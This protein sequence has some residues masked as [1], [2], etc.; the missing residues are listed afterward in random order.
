MGLELIS[1]TWDGCVEMGYQMLDQIA[2]SK[3][4][5]Q[6]LQHSLHSV[7]RALRLVIS[8]GQLLGMMH[9]GVIICFSV[10]CLLYSLKVRNDVFFFLFT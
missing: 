6:I 4:P 10:K 8:C 5:L 3:S 1:G 7:C 9:F 2:S